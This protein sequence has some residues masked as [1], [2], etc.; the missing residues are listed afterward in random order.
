[1]NLVQIL[2]GIPQMLQAA[3]HADFVRAVVRERPRP[4]REVGN[5]VGIDLLTKINIEITGQFYVTASEINLCLRH[6][7]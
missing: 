6:G 1:M 2:T 4:D 5:H 3:V 7:I